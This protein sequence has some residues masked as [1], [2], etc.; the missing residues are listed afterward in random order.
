MANR[1]HTVDNLVREF[2]KMPTIGRR[3][4]QKLAFYV[5]NMSDADSQLLVRAIQEVK[6]RIKYC[7]TCFNVAEQDICGI[8]ADTTRDP[9]TICVVEGANDVM[10]LE[11]GGRYRGRYH[12]LGGALSPIDGVEAGD[13]K[14][15][16][17][18]KRITPE[19]KEVVIA[20]NPSSE[21]EA[22]AYYLAKLLGRFPV[23][24]TRI[25]LGLPMGTELEFSDDI[26]L[27]KALERRIDFS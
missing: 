4:A 18:L 2:S 1:L 12:V 6:A 17:L 11:K 13:L 14:I 7:T 20:T 27:S 15:E 5:L 26:T 16:E 22:T 9:G 21:G 19:V 23:R 24:V 8:C 25:A 10:A 3:T